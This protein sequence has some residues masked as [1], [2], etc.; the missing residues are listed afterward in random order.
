MHGAACGLRVLDCVDL[1]VGR[2]KHEHMTVYSVKLS[3][4]G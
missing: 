4:C 3:G 2:C 1:D